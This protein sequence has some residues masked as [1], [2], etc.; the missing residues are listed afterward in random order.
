MELEEIVRIAIV[1]IVLVIMVVAIAL[2]NEKGG[3]LLDSI[4]NVWRFG[5]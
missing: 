1:I 2:F 4:R 5:R 3:E